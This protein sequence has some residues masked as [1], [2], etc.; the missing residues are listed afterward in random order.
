MPW[1]FGPSDVSKP[2]QGMD[3][4]RDYVV[5]N[6]MPM[7]LGRCVTSWKGV[8]KLPE[9]LCRREG[10]AGEYFFLVISISRWN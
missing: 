3:H 6:G 8:T 4:Q 9:G 2:C 5:E 7:K 1:F 10:K